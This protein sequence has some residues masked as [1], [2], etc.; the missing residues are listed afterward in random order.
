[1][2][3]TSQERVRLLKAG[4]DSKT[5]EKLYII[6]N[7]FN[8]V[9]T[10]LLIELVEIMLPEAELPRYLMAPKTTDVALTMLCPIHS[11]AAG[12]N[13]KINTDET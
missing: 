2:L 12:Y 13:D 6:S 11:R 3:E 9:R 8:I 7:N 4:I 1:M 5:I 10:S